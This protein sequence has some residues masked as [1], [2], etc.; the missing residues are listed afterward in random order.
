[1]SN[2][3]SQIFALVLKSLS[4][5]KLM[6]TFSPYLLNLKLSSKIGVTV[7]RCEFG[8][9]VDHYNKLILR[10]VLCYVTKDHFSFHNNSNPKF[11]SRRPDMIMNESKDGWV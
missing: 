5:F 6:I 1:M 9:C 2:S 8:A 7:L 3:I 10:H 4:C 11:A